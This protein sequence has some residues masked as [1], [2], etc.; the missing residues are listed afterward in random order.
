MRFTV[1]S[2]T[3][4]QAR[5]ALALDAHKTP[6]QIRAIIARRGMEA[7]SAV[8]AAMIRREF[9]TMEAA[10]EFGATVASATNIFDVVG[11]KYQ[12][13]VLAGGFDWEVN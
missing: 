1:A 12:G 3:V 9:D 13:A 6:D 2:I 5:Q 8:D 11:L 10:T 4:D 7:E